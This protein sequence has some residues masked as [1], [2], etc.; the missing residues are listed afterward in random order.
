MCLPSPRN[1]CAPA[2]K[3]KHDFPGYCLEPKISPGWS[4][5]WSAFF[6]EPETGPAGKKFRLCMFF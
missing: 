2:N 5:F 6:Q 3:K 4:G 1:L